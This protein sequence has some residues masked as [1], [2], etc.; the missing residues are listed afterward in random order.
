M[1]TLWNEFVS[2]HLSGYVLTIQL[3]YPYPDIPVY[4]NGTSITITSYTTNANGKIP[5]FVLQGYYTINFTTPVLVGSDSRRVFDKWDNTGS[6]ESAQTFFVEDDGTIQAE[7]HTEHRLIMNCNLGTTD[8]S[9]ENWRKVG[10]SLQ[11]SA[12][13]PISSSSGEQYAWVG[14]VG[15]GEGS[16]NG[17]SNPVSITMNGPINETATWRILAWWEILFRP[18]NVQVILGFLGVMLT[19]G[20]VGVAWVRSRKTRG[21]VKTFLNQIDDVYSRLKNEP[22]K[23]EEELDRLRNTILEGLTD[24]KINEE[25]YNIIDKKID[26]YMEELQKLK[27]E[28]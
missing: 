18:E 20:F 11:I 3:I 7:Y 28:K 15:I 21:I 16:Y 10:V 17:T 2:Y 14:W 5:F 26:K 22:Q 1:D 24:G 27:N 8:P 23:C 12:A 4:I 13:S 25:N 19:V 6:T 9:G